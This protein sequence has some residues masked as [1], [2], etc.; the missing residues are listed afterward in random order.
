[1]QRV[2]LHLQRCLFKH[3]CV[4]VPQL[5]A[6]I[7]A[8][9]HSSTGGMLGPGK[10]S[11]C[12]NAELKHV[13]DGILIHS[14]VARYGIS[15]RR[16]EQM[17]TK[18]VEALLH[19]LG[20]RT[21]VE[22]EEIGR[23]RL[24]HSSEGAS[25]IFEPNPDH[26]FATNLY[27][28]TDIASLPKLLVMGEE[29]K[30]VADNTYYLPINVKALKYF[31]AAMVI[32]TLGLLMPF[33]AVETEMKEY[34][35]GFVPHFLTEKT[36]ETTKAEEP[37]IAVEAEAVTEEKSVEAPKETHVES[38]RF[39]V[40]IA[41]LSTEKQVEEFVGHHKLN[42]YPEFGIDRRGKSYRL[43]LGNFASQ[44]EALNK[45]RELH[46]EKRFKDAW[47]YKTK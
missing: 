38:N 27:S 12:F 2:V 6:F 9:E 29:T 22:L 3:P 33:R 34:Q 28:L 47:I 41:T 45:M 1:M 16:A 30:E 17:L 19:H 26:P 39:L 20:S 18:D 4:V 46:R 8:E 7:K 24:G 35:A 23:I 10:V 11:L 32:L 5:G 25:P 13:S 36:A 21:Y 42:D 31:T 37:A 40:V 15:Y 14:Y 43:Y 44:E